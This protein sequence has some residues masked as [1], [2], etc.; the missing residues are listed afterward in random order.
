[1][2]RCAEK[3]MDEQISYLAPIQRLPDDVLL[4]IMEIASEVHEHGISTDHLFHYHRFHEG[5]Q[6][7]VKPGLRAPWSSAAV[8][9]SWRALTLSAP[10]L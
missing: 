8:S 2:K 6:R 9:R 3:R 5:R 10:Q 4:M 1:M 7:D